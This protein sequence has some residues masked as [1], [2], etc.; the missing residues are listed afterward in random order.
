MTRRTLRAVAL[1]LGLAVPCSCGGAA[2]VADNS[3]AAG[4]ARAAV[5]TTGSRLTDWPEFGLNPQR[6]DATSQPTGV[7]P[8]G[9]ARMTDRRISLPGTVDS[10]PIYLHDVRVGRVSQDVVVVTTSYGKTI[11]I[12]PTTGRSLWTFTPTGYATWAGTPELTNS[13]PIADPDRRFVYAASPNGLIHKLLISD[14]HEDRAGAWPVRV[15]RDPT[16]EKLGSALNVDGP[17]VIATTSGYY[18]DTPTYQGHVALIVRATGRLAGV[19]NTLCADR[20]SLIL[21][22]TCG[23]SDSAILSRGGAVVEPGGAR[24]LI[25]TGNG[26]WNGTT[27]FGDSLIELTFPGLR[28]R[29]AYTPTDQAMLNANDLDLGSTAPALLG[30]D[31]VLIAGKDAIMRILDLARL[32]GRPAPQP[33]AL[34]GEL[35]TLPTPGDAQPFTQPAIWTHDGR[36][37]VFVADFSGTAAYTVAGGRLDPTWSNAT[38]GTSP[39]LA[40]GLL[41]VYDPRAGGIDVYAPSSSQPIAKLPGRPGHWN[42]PIVVDGHVIEP[43][44]NANDHL[45]TGTIDLFTAA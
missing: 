4:P 32:D 36:T 3:V 15:T 41:Y 27:D 26:S 2:T 42:S 34:G 25:D 33:E 14:G 18:G 45:L 44:G 16:R 37:S 21:P 11:A 20:R 7:T 31:R 5:S 10:S 9:L 39:I 12:D 23:Q 43:E 35:Q 28:V 38:P 13:S 8:A 22:T 30:H 29:Q 6:V 17:D 1:A 40:G 19:F 24:L